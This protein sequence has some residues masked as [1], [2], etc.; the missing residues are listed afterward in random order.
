[1]QLKLS[2][3]SSY[4]REKTFRDLELRQYKNNSIQSKNIPILKLPLFFITYTAREKARQFQTWISFGLN[5]VF[6]MFVLAL[7]SARLICAFFCAHFYTLFTEVIIL[8]DR[9]WV[10]FI[11]QLPQI[12]DF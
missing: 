9:F 1:M 3:I 5:G 4:F 10:T 6:L 8:R 12:V 7:A 11:F 2:T